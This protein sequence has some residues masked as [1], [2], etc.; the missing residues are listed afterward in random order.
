MAH[1]ERYINDVQRT[2]TTLALIGGFLGAGKTTLIGQIVSELQRSDLRCAVVSNDQSEGL[3]DSTSARLLEG[4]DAAEVTGACFCCKLDDLVSVIESLQQNQRP[5]VILCEPVGSCTDLMATVILPLERV[6]RS[7][8]RLA[9]FT[10]L[11]DARRALSTF[12]GVRRKGDFAK[13]VGYI[14]R[15]QVEEAECLFLNKTDLLTPSEREKVMAALQ[16]AYPEKPIFEGSAKSGAGVKPFLSM[17]REDTHSAPDSLMEVD[18]AVYARG[19]AMLGWFNA[20]VVLKSE[21][22]VSGDIWLLACA[23]RIS[24]YLEDHHYEVAHFKMSLERTEPAGTT[25]PGEVAIVNQVM[26]GEMPTLSRS[27]ER[28]FSS[29]TLL[30]NLRA[31]GDALHLQALVRSALEESCAGGGLHI[32][33]QNEAAFQPG[34]PKPTHRILSLTA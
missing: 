19:E 34:E 22:P 3:V 12:A 21:L 2:T 32:R 10:V 7:K 29:A 13:D 9:P 27:M 8:V 20:T 1:P 28:P 23:T 31:E 24:G 4:A 15:K 14:F 33:W 30:V 6:Y 18:Y 17:I 5:D 26:S 25:G 16:K 11:L